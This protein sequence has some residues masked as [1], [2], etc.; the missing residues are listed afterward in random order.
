[1]KADMKAAQLLRTAHMT[2]ALAV[3]TVHP[4]KEESRKPS[5]IHIAR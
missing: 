1:M 3:L 4:E 5:L 2:A